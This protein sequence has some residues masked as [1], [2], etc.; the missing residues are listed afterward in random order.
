V[1]LKV[2]VP[3]KLNEKQHAL[4]QAYAELEA[5]TPGIIRGITYKKD[6][7]CII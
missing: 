5:D 2:S 7:E 3:K 6:G 4:I 1:N